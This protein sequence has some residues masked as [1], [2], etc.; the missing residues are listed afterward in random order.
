MFHHV[1]L[2]DN[3]LQTLA[4]PLV[5]CTGGP[6]FKFSRHEIRMREKTRYALGDWTDELKHCTL[7]RFVAH[8]HNSYYCRDSVKTL[9]AIL[10]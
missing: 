7:P 8:R 2:L 10:P 4:R 6:L 9:I 3:K 1:D 5:R